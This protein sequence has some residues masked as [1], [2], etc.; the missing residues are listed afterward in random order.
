MNRQKREAGH[1]FF[2][3]YPYIINKK[4]PDGVLRPGGLSLTKRLIDACAFGHKA[5]VADVGCGTGV[6]VQFLRDKYGISAT[7]VDISATRLQEG[8]ARTAGLRL[9]RA[10]AE[11]LPFADGSL[12]GVLMECSLSVMQDADRVLA[13]VGR[14]L[15]PGGKLGITDLYFRAGVNSAFLPGDKSQENNKAG[16]MTRVDLA[17]LL[18]VRGFNIII[19]E[20]RTD[21]L[22]EFVARFIMEYGSAEELCQCLALRQKGQCL[23][24]KAL[25]KGLGYFLLLAEKRQ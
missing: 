13:E 15:L 19:W 20:E 12:E 5:K 1:R 24:P 8:R 18:A 22:K 16:I 7:G 14:V 10:A 6:T 3:N 4:T 11:T 21:S 17:E 2:Q 25:K 23:S 9:I